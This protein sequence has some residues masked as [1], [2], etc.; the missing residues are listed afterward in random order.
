MVAIFGLDRKGS[1]SVH[2]LHHDIR[3]DILRISHSRVGIEQNASYLSSTVWGNK[4]I[5]QLLTDRH[6]GLS[7]GQSICSFAKIPDA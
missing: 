7:G 2:D 1:F 6:F 3:G 5:R 4:L